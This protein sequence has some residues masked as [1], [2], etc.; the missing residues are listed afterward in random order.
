M[1][2]LNSTEL[3]AVGFD[4]ISFSQQGSETF[5]CKNNDVIAL[6]GETTHIKPP[7]P[8]TIFGLMRTA[9]ILAASN[10]DKLLKFELSK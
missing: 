3:A 2:A 10:S 4:L 1:F 9:L 7:E 5:G 8:S 6:Q